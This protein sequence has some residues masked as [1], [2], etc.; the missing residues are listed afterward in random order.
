MSYCGS[1]SPIKILASVMYHLMV[2]LSKLYCLRAELKTITSDGKTLPSHAIFER[3]PYLSAIIHEGLR[4]HDGIVP[5][6][7]QIAPSPLQYKQWTIPASIP[8]SCQ[9]YFIHFN[10]E[11]F[12]DPYAFEPERYW[13]ETLEE[14]RASTKV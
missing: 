13:K 14:G 6:T 8:L 10:P 2:N 1:A 4:L 11:V 3:L 9:Q 5:R 7:E 12:P